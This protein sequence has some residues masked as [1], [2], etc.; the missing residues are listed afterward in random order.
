MYT[1]KGKYNFANIMLP[2]GDMLDEMT[3]QQI[4]NILNHPAFAN[5]Y[6]AIMPDAHAGKG[7]PIGFTMKA[8]GYII[9][10][11]VSV[12]IGC[13]MTSAEILFNGEVSW[14]KF[15]ELI[16]ETIPAGFNKHQDYRK[17][18]SHVYEPLVNNFEDVAERV[19]QDIGVTLGSIGT[20]GGGKVLASRPRG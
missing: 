1:I 20:L 9:P 16:K 2:D 11:V 17:N 5:T 19:G 10:N 7:S 8:N 18:V 13:G 4:Y 6:I 15:D 3:T 14:E 12:D